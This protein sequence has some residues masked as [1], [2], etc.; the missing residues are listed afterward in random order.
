MSKFWLDDLASLFIERGFDALGFDWSNRCET[1]TNH[2]LQLEMHLL[3]DPSFCL[4]S[5]QIAFPLV[6]IHY[7]DTGMVVLSLSESSV[8]LFLSPLSPLLRLCRDRRTRA[9][10]YGPRLQRHGPRPGR[11]P[12]LA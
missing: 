9:A 5:G 7:F 12:G 1:V 6:H 4:Q 3:V 10:H 2:G 8:S 11:N